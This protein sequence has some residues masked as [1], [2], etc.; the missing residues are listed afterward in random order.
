ML[1]VQETLIAALTL[2]KKLSAKN[3]SVKKPQFAWISDAL[4]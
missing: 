1:G 3:L 2:F 4:D